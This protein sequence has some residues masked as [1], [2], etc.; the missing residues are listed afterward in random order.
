MTNLRKSKLLVL[1][2]I[3][4]L[5]IL[6][7]CAKTKIRVTPKSSVKTP[8]PV[9]DS[10]KKSNQTPAPVRDSSKKSNQTPARVVNLAKKH[11]ESGECQKAIDVYTV[12]YRKHPN[13]QALVREYVKSIENIKSAADSALY[14]ENFASAGRKYGVLRKNYAHFKGFEKKLSFKNTY[15]DEKIYYCKK[16]LLTRG[17]QEYRKENLGKAI[18]LWQDLLSI[19]PQDAEIKKLLRTAELLQKNLKEKE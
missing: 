19:D 8:A 4:L 16:V 7:S 17:F 6:Q 13:D 5:P 15:L 3:M 18:A 12:V 1:I 10:S 14:K 2:L 9:R 11:M